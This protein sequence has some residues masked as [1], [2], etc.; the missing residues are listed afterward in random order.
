M[1]SAI[2]AVTNK[3]FVVYLKSLLL[4]Q[5]RKQTS[6]T[7]TSTN[8]PAL[9]ESFFASNLQTLD[10]AILSLEQTYNIQQL[11]DYTAKLISDITGAPYY[12]DLSLMKNIIAGYCSANMSSGTA[13]DV[14]QA[15]LLCVD[16]DEAQTLRGNQV[17]YGNSPSIPTSDSGFT[18]AEIAAII[19]GIMQ[20]AC[21]A[22]VRWDGF[23]IEL[24]DSFVLDVS[25]ISDDN[26]TGDKLADYYTA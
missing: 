4:D 5:F 22:G 13:I 26:A 20:N 9:V 11:T 10:D 12:D 6:S 21:A 17:V 16:D 3:D 14:L 1:S 25:D 7:S 24:A 19:N 23:G 18:D 15:F 8:V 2:Y